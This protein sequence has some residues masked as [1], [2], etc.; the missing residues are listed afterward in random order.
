VKKLT[1]SM[2][3]VAHLFVA[4]ATASAFNITL[5]YPAGFLF[6]ATHD[7][8][9]K[10]AIDQA[11]LDIST[12]ITTNLAAINN[13]VITGT[14]GDTTA[15]FDWSFQYSS[16]TTGNAVT[17]DT[18][19]ISGG[20]V[21]IHVGARNLF[22]TTLG[23]G[24]PAGSG[25]QLNG[26]GF[27]N[28]WVGAMA[29]AESQS[30]VAYKRG[31]GPVIGT[32]SGSSALGGTTANYSIDTGISYGSLSLDWDGNNNNVKDDDT[33]LNNYWHFNHMTPVA[34]GKNDLYSVALHEI[35]HAL[36]IGAS[37]SWG[38]KVSGTSWT[39]AS[40]IGL[41][42]SGAGLI[43]GAG[44]HIAE[45]TMS[46]NAADGTPQ[47]AVM[48]PSITQGTRKKLTALD[49]AFLRDIGYSTIDWVTAPSSP[50]DFDND[51]DVDHTDLTIWQGGYG[52]NANGDTN[53]DGDT[54][55]RDFLTWQREYSGAM[56]TATTTA[57]EPGALALVAMCSIALLGRRRLTR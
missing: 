28:Q 25:F 20:T 41:M 52:V 55:G 15:T 57:P 38:A 31:G 35:L 56:L 43:N 44:D 34:V 50:A 10:N 39:G 14:N 48:D 46:T 36:G 8:V 53:N 40:V 33:Q 26:N 51:G 47:E 3:V 18:A 24:G 4:L 2:A 37:D 21:I 9:A 6:S 30:E 42:G 19:T 12:A 16:P 1:L 7:S 49:L 29:S 54:D 27:P 32:L 22:G 5:S 17:I 13:D 23:I 11:A 45:S